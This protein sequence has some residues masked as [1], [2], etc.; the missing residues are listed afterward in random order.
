MKG[1]NINEILL[2][3]AIVDAGSFVAGGRAMGVTR[4]AAGKAFGRLEDRLGVR[5][6]NRTT[7]TI[8]L[9]DEG[10]NF[11]DHGLAVLRAV[12]DAEASV[13]G[14]TGTP[15]GLLRVTMPDAY[16]RLLILPLIASYLAKWPDLQMEVSFTDRKADIVEEGFDL[17]IRIGEPPPDTR[18]VFRVVARY[19]W[20]LVAAPSYLAAHGEPQGLD[21]I[22]NHARL[23]F[24]S[25][26]QRQGWRFRDPDGAWAVAR[27]RSRLR[28][29]S[30]D[31][32]RDA[33]VAGLGI[34]FLPDFVVGHDLVAGR[35][36]RVLPGLDGGEAL[37]TAI[38]PSR[39]FLEPRVRRFI[40][41]LAKELGN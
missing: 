28:L 25:R 27:G 2:F 36:M 22:S 12:E 16:G 4:S 31:A 11:Y 41:L 1:A 9:T 26:G 34:A 5:L 17:A 14:E 13:K 40:D 33:A 37:I 8:S 35:L 29:D 38:Y 19:R 10:R 6:L 24:S 7:R 21:E 23:I 3:V 30:G 39:R 18:L 20:V 32:L 15:R